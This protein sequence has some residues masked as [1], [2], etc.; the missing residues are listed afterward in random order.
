MRP[1]DRPF[2]LAMSLS[3]LVAF[4]L[5]QAPVG[6]VPP[7]IGP[8]SGAPI[9]QT[10]ASPDFA[11]APVVADLFAFVSRRRSTARS[12]MK[13]ASVHVVG[14]GENLHGVEP[15][16][17]YA[18]ATGPVS[19]DMV[20][21]LDLGADGWLVGDDNLEARVTT[22]DGKATVTVRQLDAT[23]KAGPVWRDLP[24][25]AMASEVASS[26]D[27]S[28][29]TY[30]LKLTD[31]GLDMIPSKPGKLDVRVDM[32]PSTTA[33]RDAYM[34][35]ALAEVKLVSSRAAALPSALRWDQRNDPVTSL[36]VTARLD[37]AYLQRE[38]PGADQEHRDALGVVYSG[39]DQFGDH[40]VSALR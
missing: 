17:I 23:N 39:H 13:S 7:T 10:V 36:P 40:A 16:T 26:S 24:G 4:A 32:V 33:P 11:V 27:G 12:R 8:Q 25:F 20:L 5:V 9:P 28:N 35:R 34:P 15:G 30:E 19:E 29:V 1:L 6:Q 31:P 2:L 18:A 22:V 21:S 38:A 3:L 37:P 14:T